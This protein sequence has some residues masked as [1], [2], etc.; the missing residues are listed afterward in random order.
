MHLSEDQLLSNYYE[1]EPAKKGIDLSSLF[2]KKT[3]PLDFSKIKNNKS[4]ADEG[5][6]FESTI[7]M[8]VNKIRNELK[9]GFNK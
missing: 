1:P 7:Q 9:K 6:E 4:A 3:S 8:K 2:N 5:D